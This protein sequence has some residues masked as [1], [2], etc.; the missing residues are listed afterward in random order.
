[1]TAPDRREWRLGPFGLWGTGPGH[2]VFAVSSDAALL[3]HAAQKLVRDLHAD[4]G[5]LRMR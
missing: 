4:E 2:A 5:K 1:M 3:K